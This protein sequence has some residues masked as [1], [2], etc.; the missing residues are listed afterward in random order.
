MADGDDGAKVVNIPG[1]GTIISAPEW[2]LRYGDRAR[3]FFS[4]PAAWLI[5]VLTGGWVTY[6]TAK[7]RIQAGENPISILIDEYLF[8]TIL[9]PVAGSLWAML[10]G[11]VATVQVI[12]Y[13]DGDTAGIVDLPTILGDVVAAPFT[14]L[15]G[16]FVDGIASFNAMVA[17]SVEPLGIVAPIFVTGLWAFEVFA[18]LWIL[19]TLLELIPGVD[20]TD[21]ALSLTAPVRNFIRGL[22]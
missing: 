19:W 5:Y 11:A 10:T 3:R 1:V 15:F 9:L 18:A 14:A 6:N 2:V 21:I 17:S 20:V 13:G 8:R 12:I 7:T 16:T 22:T 4:N